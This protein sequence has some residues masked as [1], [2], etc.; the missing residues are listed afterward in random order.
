MHICG[1]EI[2]QGHGQIPYMNLKSSIFCFPSQGLPSVVMLSPG[3]ISWFL[4]LKK[5]QAFYCSFSY[6]MLCW[7]YTS[8]ENHKNRK[9]TLFWSPSPKFLLSS[10]VCL[11]LFILQ[12]LKVAVSFFVPSVISQ[13][14]E[15]WPD[16]SSLHYTRNEPSTILPLKKKAQIQATIISHLDYCRGLLSSFLIYPKW[17]RVRWLTVM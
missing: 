9:L 14:W 7:D 5:W 6:L 4:R 16:Q 3:T 11:L 2:S 13:L 17:P 15:G 1:S 12:N 8:D 10:N